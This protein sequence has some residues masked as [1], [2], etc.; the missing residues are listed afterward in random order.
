MYFYH[1]PY[2][3]LDMISDNPTGIN[4]HKNILKKPHKR[5]GKIQSLEICERFFQIQL[6][7]LILCNKYVIVRK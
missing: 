5:T 7:K 2:S 3:A 6:H 1:I 4:I